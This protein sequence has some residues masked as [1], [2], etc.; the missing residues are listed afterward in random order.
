[1]KLDKRKAFWYAVMSMLL[2]VFITASIILIGNL[3]PGKNKLEDYRSEVSSNES[4]T[5]TELPDNPVDFTALKER[6]EDVCGWIHIP[7]SEE[8]YGTAIDYPILQSPA[9]KEEDFYLDHD[10]DGKPLFDG[11]IYIQRINSNSFEDPNTVI[12]GHDLYN[13]T[14]F[15]ALRK[16]R[17]REFFDENQYIN[18]YLPGR[19][20]KYHIYSAF[21]FDD[22]H[23]LYSYDF[24][25]ESSYNEFLK[26]SL[27]PI[28]SQSLVREGVEVTTKDRI[29]TLSTCTDNEKERFLVTAVLIEEKLTK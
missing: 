18:I 29:I 3:T 9:D 15:T 10:I 13:K 7:G 1:M 4:E 6:N 8:A 28:S 12:Y 20:L 19:T 21:V 17:N 5:L 14:M 22:R 2:V 25:D 11:S 24:S 23:I 27:E 26:E 16:Y